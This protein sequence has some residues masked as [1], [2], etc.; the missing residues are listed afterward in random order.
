[1]LHYSYKTEYML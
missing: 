1:M